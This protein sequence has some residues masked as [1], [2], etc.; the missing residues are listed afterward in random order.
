[1]PFH[2]GFNS[3]VTSVAVRNSLD[4]RSRT[5]E[6]LRGMYKQYFVSIN[7]IASVFQHRALLRDVFLRG[8]YVGSIFASY[9]AI[10]RIIIDLFN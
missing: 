10:E 8:V 9:L 6:S 2:Q 3:A 1:M 5:T 4:T 7:G